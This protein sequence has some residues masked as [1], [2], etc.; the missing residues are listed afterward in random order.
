MFTTEYVGIVD[1]MKTWI[2]KDEQ[3]NTVGYNQSAP[4]EEGA[5]DA[6]IL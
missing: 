5:G 2:V 6:E 3:G 1:G 4:D